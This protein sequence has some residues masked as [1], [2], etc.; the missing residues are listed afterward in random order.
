MMFETLKRIA[1]SID[2]KK[3]TD[4]FIGCSYIYIV[5]IFA[6]YI[7]SH[8][9]IWFCVPATIIGFLT[10]PFLV[11]APHCQAIRWTI[12]T[13]GEKIFAMWVLIGTW[14]FNHIEVKKKD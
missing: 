2:Y 7:S 12:S 9:Y 11:P 5:W 1:V 4:I 6:H 13:G 10:S 8:M 3:Y 14:L